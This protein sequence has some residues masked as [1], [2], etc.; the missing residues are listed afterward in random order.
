MVAEGLA[1]EAY[2]PEEVA[3]FEDLELCFGHTLMLAFEVLDLAGSTT[4]VGAATVASV[5]KCKI[6]VSAPAT[7]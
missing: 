2:L 5:P 7:V 1:R 3:I 6:P 4:G